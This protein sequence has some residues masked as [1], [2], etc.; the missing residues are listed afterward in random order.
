MERKGAFKCP[1][2]QREPPLI[3]DIKTH[4]H[5]SHN[6]INKKLLITFHGSINTN[7][8]N[9]KTFF[10]SMDSLDIALIFD[11]SGHQLPL[12]PTSIIYTQF[13]FSQDGRSHVSI[14][15]PLL[16]SLSHE[17][18][19]QG[20]CQPEKRNSHDQKCSC[21][22]SV[23]TN[24]TKA[25]G[26]NSFSCTQPSLIFVPSLESSPIRSHLLFVTVRTPPF[27]LSLALKSTLNYA[28]E[29][30]HPED[31]HSRT[32]KC[33]FIFMNKSFITFITGRSPREQFNNNV[34][35][36]FFL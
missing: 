19:T 17:P 8:D 31:T 25:G 3:F 36:H 6:W 18:P 33:T 4:K 20:K 24:T 7:R 10:L 2:K 34:L 1:S 9:F 12:C 29:E 28:A 15:L 14:I 32:V 16:L 11:S 27:S 26:K 5:K 23:S 13:D 22:S 35:Q 30:K 21:E